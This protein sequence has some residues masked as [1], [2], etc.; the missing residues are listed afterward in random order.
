VMVEALL[1]V[2][3]L[4]RSYANDANGCFTV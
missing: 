2:A 1:I 3:R 4:Y